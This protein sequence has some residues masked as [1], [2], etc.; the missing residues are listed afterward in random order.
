MYNK[1]AWENPSED[2]DWGN[3]W[4]DEEDEVDGLKGIRARVKALE[5]WQKRQNGSIQRIEAKMDKLMW[6]HIS[7]LV[8]VIACFASVILSMLH[9]R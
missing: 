4:D 9:L 6:W 5:I 2:D 1:L 7:E 8:A 3:I